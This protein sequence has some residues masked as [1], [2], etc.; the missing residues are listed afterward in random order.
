MVD[1][2]VLLRITV[3]IHEA[4]HAV[5]DG[6]R[7]VLHAELLLPF[8]SGPFDEALVLTELSLDVREVG[9]V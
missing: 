4:L 2:R 7:V 5:R 8:P 6:A 9:T 3:L 1:K